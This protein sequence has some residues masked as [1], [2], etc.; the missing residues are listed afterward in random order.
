VSRAVAA[1]ATL[2]F[3]LAA[4]WEMFGPLLAGHYAS[5]ASVGIIA[6][7]MLRFHILGPVWEYTATRPDPGAYY[8]HH[9]WGI[10]WT[11]AALMEL[12]GRHD[13]ICRLAPV[14]Q[15]VATPPLL[16]AIGR[17]ALRPAAGA[18]A[19][20]GFVVLPISLAFANFNALEVPV[21]AFGLLFVWGY[22]R[23][24]Q[25]GRRR[26][27]C[28]MLVGLAFALNADWPAFILAG[29][30]TGLGV[31][32]A[33]A[34]RRF[35][36]RPVNTRRDAVALAL[37]IAFMLGTLA[38]YYALFR[39]SGKLADLLGSYGARSA[40][41]AMKL[42]QV[43]A[44]RRYWIELCFTPTAIALG[45]VAAVVSAAR[46]FFLRR[47]A[48]AMPLA[49]LLMATVQYVVF[50]EGADVHVFWPHYFAAYFA[51]ALGVLVATGAEAALA[52][53]RRRARASSTPARDM[54]PSALVAALIPIAVIA[55]DGVPALA[56][57]RATGG[58]FNEKGLIIDSD[59]EKTAFL[60]HIE[61]QLPRPEG[62]AMHVGMKATWSQVWALG[63]RILWLDAPLP[64]AS[65]AKGQ[66]AYL[67]DARF[68][69]LAS[70]R[71]LA[72]RFHVIAAG[73]FWR[74]DPGEPAAPISASSFEER[75]PSWWEW[76]F[77]SGT[78]PVRRVAPDPYATWELRVHLGQP[79]EPPRE[80]PYTL[81]Q[82]R[83][84]HNIA[85]LAGDAPSAAARLGEIERALDRD[86]PRGELGDGGDPRAELVGVTFRR[87]A[88]PELT[89]YVRA[90][91]PA[92]PGATLT[93]RSRVLAK[94]PLS[95]TMA[96][97]TTREVGLPLAIPPELWR[98]GLLYSDKIPIRKRPGLEEFRAQLASP[99]D[100]ALA[101]VTEGAGSRG[102]NAGPPRRREGIVVLSLR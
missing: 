41:N 90:A 56:Y 68:L 75:E 101:A 81:E 2:W 73:P 88:R 96:D 4:S 83:V 76:Y 95:L 34:L 43:L 97:P 80:P 62:V 64:R 23:L 65:G 36:P 9:P 7:N 72:A 78:E 47:E 86:G 52:L 84:A 46:L 38:L 93:V 17:S 40:G 100:R 49:I 21:I 28:A 60:R 14:L 24:A 53:G 12:F 18:A 89:L 82:L 92:P 66:R 57:A 31:L 59:G 63:G 54:G 48:E 20:A 74:V 44:E 94:A 32:R 1:V 33:T 87:G 19:A 45:K 70:K 3:T 99:P 55:R 22:L 58:R 50:K 71:E 25:T 61:P 79:A 67:A 8:C 5:S 29:A 77:L 42:S 27:L 102:A 85:V 35:F 98:A 6:D 16:Y 26:Y 69:P 13:F 11:T 91:G 39:R 10:F 51:L 30:V 37:S 15:S